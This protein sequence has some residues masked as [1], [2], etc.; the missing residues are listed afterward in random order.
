MSALPVHATPQIVAA[1][2]QLSR[3]VLRLRDIELLLETHRDEWKLAKNTSV[4][5]LIASLNKK[6][7]LREVKLAFPRRPE[8]VYLWGAPSALAVAAGL[9]SK[10]YLCHDT[11]MRLHGLT[12]RTAKAIYVNIEQRPNYPSDEPLRQH[13]IDTAFSRKQRLTKHR[14][15]FEKHTI[16]VVN[17]K[18]T[19]GLGVT[20]LISDGETL[21]VTGIERTLI[22][23]TV[24]PAY[25]G[26]PASVLAAFR[27]AHGRFKPQALAEMLDGIG[28]VYPYRQPIGFYLERSGRYAAKD[29]DVFRK[30]PFAND[31]YLDYA[32][33]ERTYVKRWRLY[34]PA[35]LR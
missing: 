28:F 3:R 6:G 15:H 16:V 14:A 29:L 18:H 9:T 11:A 30:Q 33:T 10:A 32:M 23:I 5:T 17:G 26:G 35:G 12:S 24:R 4:P 20:T 2:N 8:T 21:R 27:R 34:V 7:Q 22:D 31:F 13:A 19:N 1:F 25:A